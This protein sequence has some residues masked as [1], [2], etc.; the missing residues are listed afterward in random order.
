MR[1]ELPKK[2]IPVLC[3]LGMHQWGKKHGYNQY[4][5]QVIDWSVECARCGKV[6]RWVEAKPG[7]K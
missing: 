5:S 3:R 2:D 4:S 6:K 1:Q 7:K